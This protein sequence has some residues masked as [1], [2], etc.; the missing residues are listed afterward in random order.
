[1]K[2]K[3]LPLDNMAERH[4]GLTPEIAAYYHQAARVC[5]DRHH[6]PPT[7][8]V[9]QEKAETLKVKVEWIPTDDRCKRAWA[10]IID[11]TEDGAYACALAATE[12]M[13]GLVAVHRAETETGADYY[14]APIG[15]NADDLEEWLRLEVSG[16]DQASNKVP[17]V[18]KKKVKQ[19]LAGNSNLPAIAAVVGFK[20]Q[21]IMIQSVEEAT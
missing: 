16:T 3:T 19:A 15:Q 13:K 7:E 17:S 1:M 11:T 18:L 12:L 5:F 10:N 4:I 8:F 14:V 20:A 6:L 9:L 21:L 2:T